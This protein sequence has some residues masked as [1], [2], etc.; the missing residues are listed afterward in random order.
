MR[1]FFSHLSLAACVAVS[2][3]KLLYVG[4]NESGGEFG[5]F[6]TK[7]QGL[8][9]T[10]GVDYAF[11]NK[12][13]V[14][15]FVD[16]EK[17]NLFR[18]TFLME[19]MCPLATGLG[20][21]FNE[22]YFAEYADAVNYISVTKGAYA[23]LDP[24]NYM[25][26]NDPSSQPFSGSIIGNTSD[27]TAATTQQF[28]AFW[29]ELARRF[30]H[31]PKIIFGLNNEPHTMPTELIL[32]NNQAAINGI[33]RVGAKQLILAPGN[34]FTG[35]HTWTQVTNGFAPSSDFLNKLQ[36][37][38]KNTAIDIHEYLDI[39]FSGQ[40]AE[41]EQP[42]PSNLA[43][44]TAWLKENNLKAMVTEFGGGNNQNCFNFL[45]DM[46]TY[47]ANN[48][49]YIGWAIWA[50]G[51]FW[52]PFS[53]CCG[54]DTGSL[55]P[56]MLNDLGQPNAFET[57]WPAFRIVPEADIDMSFA[58]VLK[59][60]YAQQRSN[61]PYHSIMP[62]HRF[63][64]PKNLYTAADKAAIAEAITQFYSPRLL[65][66]FY[67]VVFFVE[68]EEENFYYGADAKRAKTFVRVDVEHIARTFADE[69]AKK[70]FM[71]RYEKVLEPF[72]KARGINWEVQIKADADR[73]LW[74]ENGVAPPEANS[75]EE[76]VWKREN[77]VVYAEELAALKGSSARARM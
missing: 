71:E 75:E 50:A 36:D 25:R 10:F 1:T 76:D 31:N 7:G 26:Y 13:T 11:I 46:L 19:R 48:P 72:T 8:P 17:I 34:G 39:D 74:R 68:L 65:P 6:G 14:D 38:E 5:V 58:M 32:A 37:P 28:G 56:G 4:V 73:A 24:H 77:R 45:N 63:Y 23:L 70:T 40:H 64:V 27:P 47:L 55:E 22:T 66:R 2:W 3:A 30:A 52:G 20:A 33:R 29:Q 43:N 69:G 15:I 67:V 41:C 12:S 21:T 18:V 61:T 59:S 60:P 51:P 54:A 49:E 62:L 16:Q 53:P 42:G 44:L 57:V 35:G 9:G